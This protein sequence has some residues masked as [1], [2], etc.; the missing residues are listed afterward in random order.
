[1][2]QSHTFESCPNSPQPRLVPRPPPFALL[3]FPGNCIPS[4]IR[5]TQS[6]RM[7]SGALCPFA[8]RFPFSQRTT[9]HHDHPRQTD[10]VLRIKN[11]LPVKSGLYGVQ[12]IEQACV[13][14][15]PMSY[16]V[17]HHFSIVRA[18]IL[19]CRGDNCPID[20]APSTSIRRSRTDRTRAFEVVH[21][22]EA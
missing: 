15:S 4:A 10:P 5:P 21:F 14:V 3:R 12:I 16:P 19:D 22:R 9:N 6:T 17:V 7:L 13:V 11:H 20:V 18:D 8:R 2:H 1:M